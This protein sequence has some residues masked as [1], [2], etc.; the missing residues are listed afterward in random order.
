MAIMDNNDDDTD[1]AG[2]LVINNAT[3]FVHICD[4]V[5]GMRC[6]KPWPDDHDVVEDVPPDGQKCPGCL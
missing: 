2:K 4:S 3:K 1:Y 5:D 6:G